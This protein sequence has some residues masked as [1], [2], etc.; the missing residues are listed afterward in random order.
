MLQQQKKTPKEPQLKTKR[1]Q[2]L[3]ALI[4]HQF[5]VQISSMS[6]KI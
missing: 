2:I 4:L 3:L 5:C 6:R 1:G